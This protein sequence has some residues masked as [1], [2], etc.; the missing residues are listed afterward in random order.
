MA[1]RRAR[2]SQFEFRSLPPGTYDVRANL[3]G[4]D[5]EHA[6]SIRQQVNVIV[7]SR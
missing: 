7:G 6:P 3:Y 1:T 5:G 2:T 4:S